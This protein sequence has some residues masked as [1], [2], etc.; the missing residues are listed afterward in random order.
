MK[1][2]PRPRLLDALDYFHDLTATSPEQVLHISDWMKI[3]IESMPIS[4]VRIES[5]I[6]A[7]GM[8]APG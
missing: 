1:R 3:S 2:P 7:A 8:A 4:L 5:R 6:T